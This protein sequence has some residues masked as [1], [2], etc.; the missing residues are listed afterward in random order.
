MVRV[1]PV[2]QLPYLLSLALWRSCVEV[3]ETVHVQRRASKSPDSRLRGRHSK[4]QMLRGSDCS[5]LRVQ[6][7]RQ[8]YPPHS[9]QQ[10]AR[11][12][13]FLAREMI[14][15]CRGWL[16]RMLASRPVSAIWPT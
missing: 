2:R 6:R 1:P 12:P 9:V 14:Q 5:L 4:A 15:L 7:L 10:L 11:I 3:Q 16:G 13:V 8:L